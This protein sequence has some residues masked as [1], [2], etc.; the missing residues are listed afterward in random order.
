MRV[1]S[2]KQIRNA[3]EK[4]PHSAS[5]LDEWYRKIK[6]LSPEDFAALRSVFPTVDKVG[7]LHVFNIGGNKLKIGRA[8]V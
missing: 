5:A 1:I 6:V 8:H 2:A 3:K 7:V 4:W